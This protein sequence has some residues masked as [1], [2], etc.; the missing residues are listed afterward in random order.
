M[1]GGWIGF[2][3]AI[4]IPFRG[5]AWHFHL[6]LAREAGK[7]LDLLGDGLVGLPFVALSSAAATLILLDELEARG[8]ILVSAGI[9]ETEFRSVGAGAF[10]LPE[11]VGRIFRIHTE[12]HC[13]VH[14]GN[15]KCMKLTFE[16]CHESGDRGGV[17]TFRAMNGDRLVTGDHGQNEGESG[18]NEC[19]VG[20]DAGH[21]C[22]VADGMD[23]GLFSFRRGGFLT[24]S[25]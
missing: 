18:G 4:F 12:I 6:R 8:V 22:G 17:E 2:E 15:I 19:G 23:K 13:G 5:G 20:T 10:D 14:N 9:S 11:A 1:R 24:S 25:G 3:K 7:N 21:G 16:L